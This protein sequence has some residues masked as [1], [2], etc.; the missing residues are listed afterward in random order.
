MCEVSHSTSKHG[1][2]DISGE[3]DYEEYLKP[4]LHTLE[5]SSPEH[6]ERVRDEL[7]RYME[8]SEPRIRK[9]ALDVYKILFI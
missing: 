3:H 9:R 1:L 8:D 2:K 5:R 6:K 4:I 7:V